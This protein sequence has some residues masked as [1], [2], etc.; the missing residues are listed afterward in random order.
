MNNL[1]EFYRQSTHNILRGRWFKGFYD[2]KERLP[3]Y[4]LLYLTGG[5]TLLDN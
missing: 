4:S 3:F 5:R 1:E 2:F